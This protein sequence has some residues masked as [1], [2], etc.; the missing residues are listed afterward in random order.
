[1]RQQSDGWKRGSTRLLKGLAIF[2]RDVTES[3][4]LSQELQ[5][6]EAKYRTLVEQ[7]PAV[8]YLLDADENETPLYY[9]P[10]IKMLSGFSIEQ[11]MAARQKH[12]LNY[13]HPDD[14][15]RVALA[16]ENAIAAGERFR[17]EYRTLCA[18]GSYVW[19]FDECVPIRDSAGAVLAWQGILMDITDR[20]EAE[21][22]RARLAAIV[23]GAEDAIF[24]RTLDGAIT[25]W[26]SGAERLFGWPASEMIGQSY[27]KIIPGG[28]AIDQE[29]LLREIGQGP[30]RFES[31]RLRADG[32]LI[33]VAV[34]L[35]PIRD[36]DGHILGIASIT[37]DITDRKQAD[38]ALRKA[39]EASQDAVRSKAQMLATMSHE[40]RT[41]LQ[42]VLGYADF[43]LHG[44]GGD[45]SESQRED[46]GFIR[47]GATRMVTLIEQM[48]DLSRIEVGKVRLAVDD[49]DLH[50]IIEQ[51]R[52][53]IAPLA[54]AKGLQV[55][56][57]TCPDLPILRLDAMRVRQILLNLAGN[58]VK[59]TERGT[60]ALSAAPAAGGEIEIAVRRHGDR[61]R[62]R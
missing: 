30:A 8:V 60:I 38:E 10:Y 26:N 45:L 59:F 36:Q 20:I 7:L 58:A 39:L 51:V 22:V 1:M 47:N 46:V 54:E 9:S 40:L 15:A 62:G 16:N 17:A 25:S 37:R 49:V 5:A 61:D 55:T 4:S 29:A 31:S 27:L 21:G 52:Q 48:L 24:S 28:D 53:D 14:H 3:R 34:S 23:E 18:D 56:I 13:V 44:L 42:A 35:S 41:P 57:D 33:D 50:E 19:V 12:W 11:M 6:S 32:Q 2:L 43:L